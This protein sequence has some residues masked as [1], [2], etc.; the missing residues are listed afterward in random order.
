MQEQ[1]A[2]Q[3]LNLAGQFMPGIHS[4]EGGA[5]Q[6]ERMGLLKTGISK[7]P[8]LGGAITGAAT[9][10]VGT[11]VG[12]AAGEAGQNLLLRNLSKK[13]AQKMQETMK[14]NYN[15]GNLMELKK[16]NEK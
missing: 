5:M 15:L 13:D 3:K 12:V 11:G 10:G 16:G 2:F 6:A 1:L 9:K 14:S 7:L 8:F 4:Y